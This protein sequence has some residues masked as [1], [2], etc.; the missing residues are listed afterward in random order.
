MR[1]MPCRAVGAMSTQR[2]LFSGIFVLAVVAA[3][4]FVVFQANRGSRADPP[5][6]IA[7]VPVTTAPV[8]LKTVPVRLYA[9]GNVEPYTTVAVK[10]RV[11]GQLVS[12]RFKEGDEVRQGAVL[13]E[14][15]A[16]PFAASLK[17][18]QANLLKDRALYDRAKEQDKRYK[19][20]LAKNFISTDAYEQV[21]TN[22]ETAA[23][24]VAADEAAID[25]AKLSLEYCT[26][27]SPV[28]GYAGRIQIQQGNLVK[29]NDTNAMVTLNQ[30]VPIYTSFSVPEQN[31]ADVRRYQADGELKVAA[32]FANA[33]HPPMAGRLSFV[34][35]SADATTGTIKLK[36]EFPN[37]DKAL[38][39]GQF[40]NVVLT[41]REQKDAI[42]TPSSSVQSGPTGQYVFV[43]KADS[44]VELRNITI[45]RA[46]GDDTVVAS[47]LKA[48]DIVVT[49]GQLRLAPGTKV[50]VGKPVES[51][52]QS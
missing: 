20:L 17:Q 46:E 32:S 29:A 43:V 28:T 51:P 48:G 18:A 38:W 39:P 8:I 1:T 25:N 12:V 44:T 10:A 2:K 41:L 5:K 4:L 24:T 35:N 13:F 33:T 9:I 23:A 50:N 37:S 16:R 19:D 31:V 30:V 22:A 40:V 52:A 26:I 7:A 15:D 34:D 6:S 49:V 45:T 47:G 27:R 36:A 14:I 11:D 21:R 42:V 3:L